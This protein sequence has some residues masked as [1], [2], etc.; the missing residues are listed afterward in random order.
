MET[1]MYRYFLLTASAV[2]AFAQPAKFQAHEVAT[3]L[4]GGYQVVIED[5][6]H[7]GKPDLIGLASNLTELAWFE[8]PSWTK[9][10]I[11]SGIRQPINLAVVK[12]DK[13]GVT[14]ALATDFSPNAKQ[15]AG[16]V[17][18]LESQGD[19]TQP[20]KRT[21][22]DALSTSH[23]LRMMNGLVINQPL[24]NADAVA[25][26]YRGKTP[27]VFYK[28]GEWKRQMISDADD[29]VAHCIY[30]VDWDH[31]G[32][33]QLLT[34][35]MSGVFLIR[36]M[37]DGTWQRTKL[38]AGDPDAWP[39]GGASDVAVGKLGNER[40]LTTIEPWHG[41]IV[42]F[43]SMEKGAWVRHVIDDQINDGHTLLTANLD[44][45]DRDVIIAGYRRGG[46]NLYR[47][48]GKAWQKSVL[49]DQMPA[50]GCAVGDL[51]GDGKLD[52]ACIGTSSA[53][54]KWYENLG[55]K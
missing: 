31:D 43:Y 39:K 47:Y 33:Q 15:S 37:K 12:S 2:C 22:I 28:P 23:R 24:T 38:L 9:H 45:N 40:F 35:S 19:V 7:D 48:D 16:T 18:V 10:V 42:A 34:A 41:N 36:Q 54:M 53:T 25:P 52:I 55:T 5:M 20:F 49:D 27:L 32:K 51:N 50:A 29:G 3:G 8:N 4:R 17:M 1:L 11:V 21:D 44:G 6:N 13:S 14:I 30:P 46:L 26:D